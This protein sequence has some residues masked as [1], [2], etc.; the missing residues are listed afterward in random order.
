MKIGEAKIVQRGPLVASLEWS[1]SFGNGSSFKQRIILDS[2]APFLEFETE[3]E[4]KESHK[5]LKV[6]SYRIVRQTCCE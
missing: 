6:E 5:F 4:W 2:E 3:V 1:M